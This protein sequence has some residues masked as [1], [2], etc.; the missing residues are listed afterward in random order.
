MADPVTRTF[1]TEAEAFRSYCQRNFKTDL[2]YSFDSVAILDGV[3]AECY[4]GIKG[5][6]PN[7]AWTFLNNMT[8]AAGAYFGEILVRNNGGTWACNGNPK[9][10]QNWCVATPRNGT[11]PLSVPVFGSVYNFLHRGPTETLLS[12]AAPFL[13][14]KDQWPKAKTT[15]PSKRG[16]TTKRGRTP[17]RV[18]RRN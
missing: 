1:T 17:T 10:L 5:M 14:A 16:K 4:E 7:E 9:Q 2:N 18:V 6:N 15:T 3:L 12:V 13:N 8:L 11:A